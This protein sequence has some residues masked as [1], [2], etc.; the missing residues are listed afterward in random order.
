MLIGILLL[1]PIFRGGLGQTMVLVLEYASIVLIAAALWQRNLSM[2]RPLETIFIVLLLALPALYVIPWP[3]AFIEQLPSRDLYRQA[4]SLGT[5][6]GVSPPDTI[7]VYPFASELTWLVLLIPV[8]VY[9]ATRVL[10][11]KSQ[12][13]LLYVFLFI[14]TLQALLALMQFGAA[15]TGANFP[16][17]DLIQ[18]NPASGTFQNRNHLAG[19]MEM[20]FP[21]ALALFLLN[22]GRTESRGRAN[23]PAWRRNLTR[24]LG[25]AQKPALGF[26][27]LTLLFI[28][29]IITSKSRTGIA[30]AMLGIVVTAMAF[31]RRV[32]GENS[33][34]L[35]GQVV[36]VTIAL[37]VAMGLA[38]VLDRFSDGSVAGDAR[39]TMAETTFNAAGALLP[40]GSGP[41]T[42]T[43]VYPL[44]QP[45]ELGR[46]FINAA[47]NDYLQALFDMGLLAFALVLLFLGLY[48]RQW[49]RLITPES[50]SRY[51]S[52]QIGAGIGL[53]LL[54]LHSLTDYNL[55]TPANLVYFAFLAGLF[56]S[57]PG[58]LGLHE[59][60]QRRKRRTA[61][62]DEIDLSAASLQ[63]ESP[64]QAEPTSPES[65]PESKPEPQPKP[66]PNNPF[67]D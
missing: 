21:L 56:F 12:L 54:M 62:L 9:L 31:S 66:K 25:S 39:W 26:A 52:V 57:T 32:G 22:F 14:A 3:S 55:R 1:A 47:H 60:R 37:G 2:L 30:L 42:Y 44:Y 53:L 10:D 8:G 64:E 34:G 38:P 5:V 36:T 6:E 48:I 33:F 18:R 19:M 50:W 23:Q 58:K 13:Q 46:W 45:I 65:K 28:I 7:S 49:V 41:G 35:V 29:A 67:A 43:S 4:M 63:P 59:R 61:S 24:F 40:W 15:V 27:I 11:E 20:A 16:M 51:R 17:A